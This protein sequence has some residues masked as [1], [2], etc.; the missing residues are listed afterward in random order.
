MSDLR[1]RLEIEKENHNNPRKHFRKRFRGIPGI[2]GI[3]W[4]RLGYSA[5]TDA[6][7]SVLTFKC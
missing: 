6:V 3:P 5:T 7:V 4:R 1:K 2:L